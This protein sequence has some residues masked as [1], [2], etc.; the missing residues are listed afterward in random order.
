MKPSFTWFVFAIALVWS[1]CASP[2]GPGSKTDE[3]R[4][5]GGDG[6]STGDQGGEEQPS[7]FVGGSGGKN[8]TGA[9]GTAGGNVGAGAKGGGGVG[10]S[11]GAA[12]GG[13]AVGGMAGSGAGAASVVGNAALYAWDDFST[14]A[15]DI[16]GNGADGE[17]FNIGKVSGKGWGRGW[18]QGE[19]AAA[20]YFAFADTKPL[21]FAG[22]ATS[23]N[24]LLRRRWDLGR[25]LDLKQ[26]ALAP[27]VQGEQVAKA[28]TVVWMSVLV[29]LD[30]TAIKQ[31][32]DLALVTL[33]HHAFGYHYYNGDTAW[34][35]GVWPSRGVNN[36]SLWVA[37]GTG[38]PSPSGSDQEIRQSAHMTKKSA[39][40]GVTNLVVVKVEISGGPSDKVSLYVDPPMLGG[41]PP[42]EPDAVA[43]TGQSARF[44]TFAV[45]GNTGDNNPYPASFDEVRIGA[46]F[47]AVTPSR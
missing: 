45:G 14:A 32:N 16:N 3:A 36:W 6:G 27:L 33:H 39:M 30:G 15:G 28:G 42:A 9:G 22:L 24:Y 43:T 31:N 12:A 18:D 4:E 29:R 17:F 10:G 46:S 20:G 34:V 13:S 35:A 40:V 2:S 23:G 41:A 7:N 5:E 44:R 47:A 1:D 25:T 11:A 26:S 38:D 8:T 21:T 19:H 37:S